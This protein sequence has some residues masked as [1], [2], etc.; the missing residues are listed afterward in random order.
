MRL[1][2]NPSPSAHKAFTL[3]ELVIV[4]GVLT[5]VAGSAVMM[6]GPAEEQA[7]NQMSQVELARIR[8]A[9][10]QFHTDT[11]YLPKQG[12]FAL[13]SDAGSVP[14][15]AEGAT[16][17]YHPANLEQLYSNPLAGTGHAL[18]NWDP[19]TKRGW[20]GPYLSAFGEGFVDIGDDLLPDGSG[21]PT[22]GNVLAEVR[23][24]AD[25]FIAAASG[26]FFVWRFNSGDTPTSSWGRPYLLVDAAND[27]TARVI[28]LGAN[29]RYDSGTGDDLVYP[30]F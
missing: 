10:R 20:R 6:I 18:E 22:Q 28:G 2:R 4:M 30:I 29:R 9:I 25:P 15:P 24:V 23:A 27:A 1:P 21:D 3:L 19:D 12:P 16:W 13:T 7:R 17:F 14:V 11:G 26:S 5:A 8:D